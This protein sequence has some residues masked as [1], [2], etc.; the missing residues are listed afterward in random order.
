MAAAD[1]T[2]HGRFGDEDVDV[3]ALSPYESLCLEL[4]SV[5][6][7]VCRYLSAPSGCASDPMF[8]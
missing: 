6:E 2:E 4:R 8:F 3:G 5:E 7:S 1:T